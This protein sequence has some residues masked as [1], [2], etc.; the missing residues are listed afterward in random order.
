MESSDANAILIIRYVTLLI[1]PALFLCKGGEIFVHS[2]LMLDTSTSILLHAFR[3]R[4]EFTHLLII[5]THMRILCV[6]TSATK[7]RASEFFKQTRNYPLQS[8]MAFASFIQINT[9]YVHIIM[10]LNLAVHGGFGGDQRRRAAVLLFLLLVRTSA[11]AQPS[12]KRH[13]DSYLGTEFTG[14]KT[15]FSVC[16]DCQ[17]SLHNS[18]RPYGHRHLLH[19]G[20]PVITV[21]YYRSKLLF[22]LRMTCVLL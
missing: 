4:W 14:S 19:A 5:M 17:I 10:V 8:P 3:N 1:A 2:T 13:E 9:I 7:E 6:L 16:E 11:F 21:L 18:I 12:A 15:L 20:V 22:N